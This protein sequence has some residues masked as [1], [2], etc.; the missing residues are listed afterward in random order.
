MYPSLFGKQKFTVITTE[1]V[2]LAATALKTKTES[3]CGLNQSHPE[4]TGAFLFG[5]TSSKKDAVSKDLKLSQR[6]D[7]DFQTGES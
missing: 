1:I 2:R 5:V 6:R 7:T 3:A 4:I